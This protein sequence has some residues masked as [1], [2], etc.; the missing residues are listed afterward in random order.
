MKKKSLNSTA[1]RT[2]SLLKTPFVPFV[3]GRNG[4]MV[5]TLKAV[6]KGKGE[7]GSNRRYPIKKTDDHDKN[8]YI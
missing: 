3:F 6:I 1:A 5:L 7:S 4:L 8:V 2:P